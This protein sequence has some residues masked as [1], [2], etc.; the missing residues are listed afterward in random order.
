M[1]K[2]NVNTDN[3]MMVNGRLFITGLKM[4]TLTKL[5]KEMIVG[6]STIKHPV[7]GMMY[8]FTGPYSRAQGIAV[9]GLNVWGE[10]PR[11]REVGPRFK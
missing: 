10:S 3:S 8:E 7:R 9:P 1:K 11:T 2:I 5:L 6:G 4:N